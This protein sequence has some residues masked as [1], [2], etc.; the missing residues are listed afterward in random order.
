ML[1][2]DQR[3]SRSGK[4]DFFYRSISERE[5]NVRV[6]ARTLSFSVSSLVQTL[7]VR[8]LCVSRFCWTRW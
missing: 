1:L 6:E 8:W 3:L 5:T 4:D 7:M 2:R